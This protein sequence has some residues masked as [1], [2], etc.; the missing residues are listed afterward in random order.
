MTHNEE[1][2]RQSQVLSTNI[3]YKNNRE[4][5][6][7]GQG[8]NQIQYPNEQGDSRSETEAMET[9]LLENDKPTRII[10]PKKKIMIEIYNWTDG[11]EV[12]QLKRTN[13]FNE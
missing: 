4:P 5:E 9:L 3:S 13:K 1:Q 10:W 2:D 8:I 12:C 7:P 6:L 11:A